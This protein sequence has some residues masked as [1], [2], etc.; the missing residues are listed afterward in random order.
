M[1]GRSI[2]SGL[3]GVFGSILLLHVN[4]ANLQWHSLGIHCL[5]PMICRFMAIPSSSDDKPRARR[6]RRATTSLRSLWGFVSTV[7]AGARGPG[8]TPLKRAATGCPL[9][10]ATWGKP[11]AMGRSNPSDTNSAVGM[12]HTPFTRAMIISHLESPRLSFG[13]PFNLFIITLK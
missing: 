9:R 10:G 4:I 11:S 7:K 13:A 12:K 3:V 2:I 6:R 5:S 8:E 1:V